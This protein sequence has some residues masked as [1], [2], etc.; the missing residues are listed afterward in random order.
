MNDDKPK[1]P[2]QPVSSA[3]PAPA[4]KPGAEA[5]RKP[6]EADRDERKPEDLT[7]EDLRLMADTM[8]GEGPG[9]D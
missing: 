5:S 1:Q 8:P 4:A 2:E 7:A 3:T 6:A 9:D